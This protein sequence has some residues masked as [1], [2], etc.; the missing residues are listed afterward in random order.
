[1]LWFKIELAADPTHNFN[2]P[3]LSISVER[4]IDMLI[5]Q[6]N[7][8]NLLSNYF[9]Y[10]LSYDVPTVTFNDVFSSFTSHVFSHGIIIQQS[11]EF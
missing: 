4:S 7:L 5:D 3:C 9:Y 6:E 1:M 8:P 11:Y 10:P 2:C